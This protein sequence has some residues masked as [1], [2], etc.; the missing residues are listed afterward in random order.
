MTFKYTFGP[1]DTASAA[2]VYFVSVGECAA[3]VSTKRVKNEV[4][5]G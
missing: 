2:K 1:A 5:I 3:A 4:S